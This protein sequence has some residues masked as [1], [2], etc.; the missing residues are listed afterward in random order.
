M[1]YA[2]VET[3][4]NVTRQVLAD[5]PEL[6]TVAFRFAAAGAVGALHHHPHV[7]STFVQSGRFRFTVEARDFEVGPGDAFVIP[8]NAVHG[9]VCL[10]PGTL[11]D[12]FTPR[13]NDFL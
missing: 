4:E 11:I 8:S 12:G 13:R 1:T 9:C 3:G 7:Q 10:E 6:M 5:A 2:I